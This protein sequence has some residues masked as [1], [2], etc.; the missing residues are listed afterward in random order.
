MTTRPLR[1]PALCLAALLLGACAPALHVQADYD[2][3]ADFSRLHTWSW[4]GQP[5]EEQTPA[6]AKTAERIHLEALVRSAVQ[7]ELAAKGFVESAGTPDFRVSWSFGEWRRDTGHA[8]GGGYGTG[9]LALPGAHA[10]AEPTASDGRV[11][12]PSVDPF[13]SAYEEARLAVRITDGASQ[14]V[15]W[16]GRV[17]DKGDFGYFDAKQRREIAEAVQEI[18][19]GFPPNPLR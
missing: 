7:R 13:S 11:P 4:A 14:K 3:K 19:K 18:L 2:R 5:G 9:G 8:P 15:L 10:V 12:P 1:F 6:A 17:V 16:E